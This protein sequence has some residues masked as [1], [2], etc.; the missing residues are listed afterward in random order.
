MNLVW[1][2]SRSKSSRWRRDGMSM[3]R[4]LAL[5]A[6]FALWLGLASDRPIR[7]QTQ[8]EPLDQVAT[9][10][11][12]SD[13]NWHAFWQ[14]HLGE[15]KG[16]WTRYAPSGEIEDTFLSSRSFIANPSRTEVVQ[17]NRYSYAS[18]GSLKKEW[19]YT[20]KDHSRADGLTHPAYAAMRGLAFNNGAAALFIPTLQTNQ[21][22]PFEFF[23]KHGDFRYSVALLYGQDGQLKRTSSI[24]EEWGHPS[25]TLWTDN[26]VQMKPWHP[27]G[28]W[29]GNTQQ[30]NPDLTQNPVGQFNWQWKATDQTKHYFPDRI[31]LRCP[32]RLV[33][34][35]S[36]SINVLWQVNT[37]ELQTISAS[38][39]NQRQLISVMHQSLSPDS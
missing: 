32:Q 18:G 30:I 6:P 31:I 35:Q 9:S 37:K 2:L 24:R 8:G 36:F 11:R 39:N 7:S 5:L 20:L 22:T 27:K 16:R 34:G 28:V 25:D 26:V 23:L 21:F 17:V 19:R 33:E 4:W 13:R 29:K 10:A 12:D 14:H 1:L 38:Y 15:W 3:M